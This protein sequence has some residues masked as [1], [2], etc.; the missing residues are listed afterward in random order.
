M[1]KQ[2]LPDSTNDEWVRSD[3]SNVNNSTTSPPSAPHQSRC[4]ANAPEAAMGPETAR[5]P[6]SSVQRVADLTRRTTRSAACTTWR[7]RSTQS[8]GMSKE[9]RILQ[10]NLRKM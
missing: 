3:A 4:A 1:A 2:H 7:E 6:R 8:A 9:F 10:A 5:A